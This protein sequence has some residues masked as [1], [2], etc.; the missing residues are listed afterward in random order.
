MLPGGDPQLCRGAQRVL[1]QCVRTGPGVQLLQGVQRRGRDVSGGRDPGNV[2]DESIEAIVDAKCPRIDRELL[3]Q[4]KLL[5]SN[6][7]PL[8]Y[9]H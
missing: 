8:Y 7:I 1:P 3:S 6:P 2:P 9:Y 5:F 4:R